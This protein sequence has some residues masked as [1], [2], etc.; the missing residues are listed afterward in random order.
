MISSFS[1][2]E[3]GVMTR[4]SLAE[5]IVNSLTHGI[6]TVLSIAGLAVLV[7]YAL[8]YGNAWHV[9]SFSVFGGTLIFLYG[10]STLY[11]GISRPEI[12]K[13]FRK[14]DHSA[15]FLLIAGTYT[16][17]TL[18][19]LRGAWGW[20]I[21][22][23]IWG[24]AFTGIVLEFTKISRLRKLSL[25]IYIFMGWLCVVALKRILDGLTPS[26]FAFLLAG[27]LFYTSGVVFYLWRRIPHHH[28]IW[29]VFV[30][31]GSTF[32]YFSV[33]TMI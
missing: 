26:G 12:K 9:V 4:Y 19:T 5:E 25:A 16:P 21:F 15:I 17:F 30:L 32:H 22:G 18:V 2:N 14:L 7:V 6:G 33:L 13:W 3:E 10:T 29:H 31:L 8:I 1:T 20:T 28:G 24:L 23:I 27:G 11:H